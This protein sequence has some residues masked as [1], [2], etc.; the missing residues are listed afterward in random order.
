MRKLAAFILVLGSVLLGVRL[1]LRP[2]P[3]SPYPRSAVSAGLDLNWD[4]HWSAAPGSDN[5]PITWAD[6]DHQYSVWG[7]GGGFGG[8]NKV[9]RSSFGVA[10]IEGEWSKPN[11]VNVFGGH[12][13]LSPHDLTGKSYGIVCVD[14]TLFMWV[15]MF[16]TSVDPF[17][18]SRLAWSTDHGLTWKF[19]D[20]A[21]FRDE[22]IMMPTVCNYGRN[23]AGAKDDFVYSYLIRFQSYE[24]P[25]DYED[26]VAW[27]QCQRPGLIDLARVRR[28]Q[29][30]DRNAYMFFAGLKDG[31]PVWSANVMERVP[32]FEDPAGV[33]WCMNV[34]FNAGLGRYIL[35]TEHTETHRGN[36]GVF[37]SPNPW[38]P[39]TT[40]AYHT[41]F[42]KGHIPLNTFFWN[43]SNKWSG[44]DGR[45]FVL[46]FTGRKE[47]D[48]FNLIHGEFLPPNVTD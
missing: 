48:S 30:L 37:D 32:I 16:E 18:E 31:L 15:S 33:G 13:S 23:Y 22:G 19:A 8:T 26:K 40:I 46:I 6:D 3:K 43:F 21:F 11:A 25:D 7:D 17:K 1:I 9:G 10:R 47:N 2:E 4:S 29:I 27:L 20:W 44:A 24:G 34:S 41:E 35:T 39:W 38:G 42:G 36:I 12:A 14:G 5:W 28:D 45:D